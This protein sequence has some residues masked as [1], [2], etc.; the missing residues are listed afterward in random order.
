MVQTLEQYI[1][2]ATDAYKPAQT[3]VQK[4]MDALAGQLETTNQQINKNYAQQ[5]AGLNQQ[6]NMAAETASMQAAGSGGSFGGAANLANRKYYEQSFVPAVT[7]M[8]TNQSN[9]LAQA[10][11][12]SDD[13]RT[14][15][16]SQ[17]ANLNA[18]ANQQGLSQYYKDLGEEQARAFQ[19]AE[20]LKQRDYQAEQARIER[21]YKAQQDQLAREFQA[22]Q[23]ELSRQFEAEQAERNRQ[24]QLRSAAASRSVS[25]SPYAYM[26]DGYSNTQSQTP[27]YKNWDFGNG[28]SL[29]EYNG[30]AVYYKD[31]TP[32][33]AGEFLEGTSARGKNWDLWNDV[34]NNGVSTK[35]VGSDT[36]E[37]Y[38]NLYKNRAPY[39]LN[40]N[41][42]LRN[43]KYSYLY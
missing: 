26:D 4:Q 39:A 38:G 12:A 9:E 8:R 10:R 13:R 19:E 18:Q 33:S 3:A 2:Q 24:A 28:Y 41:A 17:I 15:Y 40:N 23:A 21:E 7:Q 29:Q 14:G 5:Q 22:Q 32:L 1:A 6:R 36:V 11:Q 20:A 16:E 27:N 25:Y 31:G 30:Q 42:S 35:G 34:W 37:M 43:S